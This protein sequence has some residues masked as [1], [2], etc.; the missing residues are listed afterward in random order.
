MKTVL[1]VED[2]KM[3][4]QGI[5]TM[6]M[7]SGVPI[8]TIM[9]CNNGE[10]ALE[11][12]KEQEIDVMFTDIRM[13][14]MDGITVLQNIR[15]KGNDVPILILTAKSEVDD[16]V[17]GLD[18]GAD[19]YLSKPFAAKEL[20]A[21]I[22]SVTRRRTEAVSSVLNVGNLS[23]DCTTFELKSST[24]T[25]RLPNKE[26][27]IMELLAA[28][29]GQ[30]ISTERFMEKIWGYDSEADV[31][32]VWV[33]ISYLRKRL[34]VLGANVKIKAARGQGYYLEIQP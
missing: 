2:E 12:L 10:T 25:I 18:S 16:R 13:P 23:L 34:T 21:R 26:F 24:D 28:N 33:Y 15:A 27:Q 6:I 31:G 19:D 17:L 1:I 32:V 8:E 30:V 14:K 20:L 29:P 11:I 9:E 3:I 22:R 5:K 7:R 4:R